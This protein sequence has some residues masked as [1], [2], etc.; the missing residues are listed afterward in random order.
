MYLDSAYV[1]SDFHSTSLLSAGHPGNY[2]DLKL[3]MPVLLDKKLLWLKTYA[4]SCYMINAFCDLN[5]NVVN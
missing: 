1:G 2:L 4:H 3:Q 5:Y